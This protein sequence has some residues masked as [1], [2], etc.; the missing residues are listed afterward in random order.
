M[1]TETNLSITHADTV[2]ETHAT[3]FQIIQNNKEV[4]IAAGEIQIDLDNDGTP[5]ASEIE[6]DTK[7]RMDHQTAQELYAS[8]GE[9]LEPTTD[10]DES[11]S[12]S[13]H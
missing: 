8:L 12:P 6:V 13:I 5:D 3:H 2:H 11:Q 9:S 1:T 4:V 7:I 10:Q